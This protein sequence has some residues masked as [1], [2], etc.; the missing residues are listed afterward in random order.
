MPKFLVTSGSHFTPFTYDELVKP[1]AQMA[2]AQNAT[3]DAYDAMSLETEALR[4]YISDKDVN[5]KR[6]YDNYTAKLKALQDNL[7]NNGYNAQARRDLSSAREGY[8]S[9]I[10]RLQ[11]AVK[12]RQER[13]K[14]YW[15]T[16]HKNPDMI[17][18]D[19]PA[20]ESLDKYI[21]D[22]NYG[23]DYYSYSGNQFM[24]EVGADAKARAN[25]LIR[26]PQITSDPRLA[27]YLTR[28]T[29]E[30]FTSD[31]VNAAGNAVEMVLRGDTSVMQTLDPASSI[32]ADVLLSHLDS[33]GAA[34]K[35]SPSE[36]SRLLD[37]G[38]A[39]LSQAIG[40][41]DIRDLSDKQW[42]YNKQIALTDHNH[43]L[44][45]ERL[46]AKSGQTS[47]EESSGVPYALNKISSALT[48]P[49]YEKALNELKKRFIKPFENPIPVVT[50]NGTVTNIESAFDANDILNN[51][52][53]ADLLG[54]LGGIDPESPT[55]GTG[56]IQ[57][58]NKAVK[59]RVSPGNNTYDPNINEMMSETG[60][61]YPYVVQK[62]ND[63]GQWI[64]DKDMTNEFIRRYDD[65]N[66]N[67]KSFNDNNPGINLKKLAISEKDRKDIYDKAGIPDY[68]PLEFAP[69]VTSTKSGVVNDKPATIAGATPDQEKTRQAYYDIIKNAY[70]KEASQRK[71]GKQSSFAFYPIKN[72]VV[73]Q[74]GK[75]WNDVF[76]KGQK[77][78]SIDF[79][80]GDVSS[81]KPFVEM[82]V[83]GDTYA[84]NPRM[85]GADTAAQVQKLNDV[86]SVVMMPI[87]HPEKVFLMG[88]KEMNTWLET[89]EAAFGDYLSLQYVD[90][91]GV[92][93]TITPL[94]VIISE[95]LQEVFRNV[96][97]QFSDKMIARARDNM[98][99]NPMQS[100][101]Y[102]SSKATGYNDDIF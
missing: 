63:K 19:D 79:F 51:L 80:Q 76:G 17:M 13:S 53:R 55:T 22:A 95:D 12:S 92:T 29:R 73:S 18:G 2:E 52:G 74:N 11:T 24:S 101:G 100:V 46:G 60:T 83:D 3:Q 43:K 99:Q 102:T 78:E 38:K 71:V 72:G 87:N 77:I 1:L 30:G 27:G 90:N 85:L 81:E 33:T 64:T 66:N 67:I 10:L 84:I 49:G 96:S 70:A 57:E 15:D 5:A 45:M 58:G 56:V 69:F 97:R 26:D 31:E 28:I 54:F 9:D 14:E 86:L 82:T 42:D 68:V 75:Q 61:E 93:K 21:A 62:Q 6:M 8:A 23:Q 35:V 7:W 88:N 20:L 4:N 36:F 44:A 39:G 59:I 94:D 37:Y 89:T 34:G 16:K 91:N 98:M 41:T 25:E 47:L 32:L 48:T 40:K 65:Y 50:S